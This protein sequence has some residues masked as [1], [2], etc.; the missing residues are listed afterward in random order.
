MKTMDSHRIGGGHVVWIN[1]PYGRGDNVG[2]WV[3][4]AEQKSR[5]EGCT[6][7]MLVPARTDTKWFHE[8]AKPRA[9][10]RFVKGRL[11]FVG[12]PHTAPFPCLVLI[13]R[14]VT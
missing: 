11:K 2:R 5:E 10:I 3:R 12:A 9:E 4:A 1:P 13:F 7:V 6:V 8:A 14:P